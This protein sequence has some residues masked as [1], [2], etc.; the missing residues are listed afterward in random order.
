LTKEVDV[1][2]GVDG[3]SRNTAMVKSQIFQKKAAIPAIDGGDILDERV[4]DAVEQDSGN[5]SEKASSS[6]IF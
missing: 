1:Q 3:V 5:M 6:K 2:T 4:H